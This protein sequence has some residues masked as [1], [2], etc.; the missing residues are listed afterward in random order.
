M[1]SKIDRR[2][3]ISG[4]T[5]ATAGTVMPAFAARA[6][7]IRAVLFH[8]GLNQ[9]GESLPDGVKTIA[10]GR[11]CNDEVK[12]NDGTELL[13]AESTYVE[14]TQKPMFN[15]KS[16]EVC[17]LCTF[18]RYIDICRQ[19]NMICFIELKGEWTDEQI[20][21]LF[22]M[23]KEKYDLSKCSL[24]SFEFDNLIKAHEAFPE[25]NIMLTYGKNCGD[26]QKSF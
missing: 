4:L 5:M 17:Y 20:N 15:D 22:N 12:F 10:G 18:E 21:D 2:T 14:L 9:W 24:Q 19:G 3:F 8:W 26:F 11:R 16:D 1:K 13:V 25:L 7:E 23:A 6:Q